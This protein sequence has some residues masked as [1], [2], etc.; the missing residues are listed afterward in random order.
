ME[1]L[2]MNEYSVTE[3]RRHAAQSVR[4]LRRQGFTNGTKLRNLYQKF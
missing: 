1:T 4:E 2:V 3:A